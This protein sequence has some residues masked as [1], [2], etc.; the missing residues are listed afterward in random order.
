MWSL[1]LHSSANIL[2]RSKN[3]SELTKMLWP[4][5]WR[6]CP[7]CLNLFL[8][9]NDVHVL[10]VNRILAEARNLILYKFQTN[11]LIYQMSETIWKGTWSQILVLKWISQFTTSDLPWP[12]IFFALFLLLLVWLSALSLTLMAAC[13][14][15][16][17]RTI[18]WITF[19][20][21]LSFYLTVTNCSESLV[22]KDN[23][24]QLCT[25]YQAGS[26]PN[27]AFVLPPLLRLWRCSFWFCDD[28]HFLKKVC[29]CELSFYNSS[30]ALS[31][32][33]FIQI[34]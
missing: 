22:P 9:E 34:Q 12:C 11:N 18:Y 31:S 5:N 13:I 10:D 33:I 26:L 2:H 25:L 27:L 6:S 14:F 24:F 28:F 7:Y 21:F 29:F 4:I 23:L 30:C 3:H 17:V 19:L 15:T 1:L 16:A 8:L 32:N 20:S